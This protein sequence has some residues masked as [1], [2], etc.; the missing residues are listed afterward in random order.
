MP[1]SRRAWD[2]ACERGSTGPEQNDYYVLSN[3]I[4]ESHL[5]TARRRTS[6]GRVRSPVRPT[7]LSTTTTIGRPV[8]RPSWHRRT[9]ADT[10]ESLVYNPA[11]RN[12]SRSLPLT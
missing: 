4:S 11:L 12:L 10:K 8:R 5:N 9:G 1:G 2:L 3:S 7:M 6:I